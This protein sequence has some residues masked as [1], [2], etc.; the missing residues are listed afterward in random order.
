MDNKFL[1]MAKYDTLFYYIYSHQ[2]YILFMKQNR[3]QK[4]FKLDELIFFSCNIQGL[5]M[6]K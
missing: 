3:H 1:K 5:L 4:A 2:I 6:C